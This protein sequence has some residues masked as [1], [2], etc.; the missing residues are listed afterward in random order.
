MLS[1]GL[2]VT[3]S[4][5]LIFLNNFFAQKLYFNGFSKSQ[6]TP[7]RLFSPL[8]YKGFDWE[9]L[10]NFLPRETK[11]FAVKEIRTFFRD[12]SQWPQLFLMAALIVIYIYNFSV[13]PLNKS[14]IKTV[15]LQNLFSFLNIGLAA[16]VLSAISARFVFPS[17]SMEGE[18]FWIVQAAPVRVKDFLWI[19]F[20]LYYIPMTILAEI[21]IISSNMLLGVSHFMMILSSMTIFFLVPAIVG[22]GIGL[23]AVYADF[24][25]ENPTNVVTSFGG[26][27]FMILS[28]GLT[29]MI[30]VL[31]AGPVY[32][33]VMVNLRGHHLSMLQIIWVTLSFVIALFLCIFASIYPIHRGIL[34]FS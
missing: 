1:M 18:A 27:L 3:F 12:S 9:N 6:T 10:L 31:E 21:L 33:I 5:M 7:Q 20:F 4:L 34:S 26:L 24:K 2:T 8:K 28:F 23:G 25:S 30:I 16:L 29:G 22:M 13:L 14:P 32:Q 19:K 15:Y 17:V 11:A